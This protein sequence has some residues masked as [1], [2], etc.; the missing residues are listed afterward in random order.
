[1]GLTAVVSLVLKLHRLQTALPPEH[2][3]LARIMIRLFPSEYITI[4]ESIMHGISSAPQSE[5]AA[6]IK[7]L[8]KWIEPTLMAGVLRT[9]NLPVKRVVERANKYLRLLP[10]KMR[11]VDADH[12]K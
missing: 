7:L 4:F 1:M 6:G 3:K 10:K 11:G 2:S 5:Q 9:A 8:R 12:N